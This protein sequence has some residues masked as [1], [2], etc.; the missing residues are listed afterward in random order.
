MLERRSNTY[1]L[2][3]LAAFQCQIELDAI[4]TYLELRSSDYD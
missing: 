1:S 2:K 4:P 3:L